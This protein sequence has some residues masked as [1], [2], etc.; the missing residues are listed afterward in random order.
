MLDEEANHVGFRRVRLGAPHFKYCRRVD[1]VLRLPQPRCARA[2]RQLIN[3][4][5]GSLADITATFASCPLCPQSGHSSAQVACPLCAISGHRG[6]Y[7]TGFERSLMILS[8]AS[9][10]DARFSMAMMA[11]SFGTPR[12][13]SSATSMR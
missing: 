7:V 10:R 5:Y 8:Y 11:N 4:R 13:S 1:A 3:V 9:L 2:P 6:C 12:A